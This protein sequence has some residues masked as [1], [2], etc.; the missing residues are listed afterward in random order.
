MQHFEM[1]RLKS[2]PEFAYEALVE[3]IREFQD[4][5]PEDRELGFIANGGGVLIHPST[6]RLWGQ[7]IVFEGV[8]ESGRRAR[9][10]QHYTQANVI[11]LAVEAVEDQ[12]RRIGFHVD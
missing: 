11:M 1:L 10:I 12:A 6:V 8:D 9:L 3:Q 4:Q 7:M 2:I 5:L